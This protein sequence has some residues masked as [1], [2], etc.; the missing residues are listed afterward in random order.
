MPPK[1]AASDDEVKKLVAANKSAIGYVNNAF[2]QQGYDRQTSS[3]L[4]ALGVPTA[5]TP[6]AVISNL[7]LIPPRT[8]GVELTFASR[9]ASA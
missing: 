3:L 1:Q 6:E 5:G 9:N 7:G 2:D 8:Y 4:R